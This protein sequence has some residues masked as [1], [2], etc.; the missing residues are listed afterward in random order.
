MATQFAAEYEWAARSALMSSN[1]LSFLRVPG[2]R[3]SSG[4]SASGAR[5]GEAVAT[6]HRPAQHLHGPID[7]H[8]SR[9]FSDTAT[10]ADM[11]G[12]STPPVPNP[13][14]TSAA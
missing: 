12:V 6:G 5:S 11:N 4:G 1:G 8:M 2:S 7:Q 3:G 14:P 10:S 13:M 9:P